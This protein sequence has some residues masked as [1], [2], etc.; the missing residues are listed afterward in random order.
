M[1]R[2]RFCHGAKLHRRLGQSAQRL[3]Q[4]ARLVALEIR[5]RLHGLDVEIRLGQFGPLGGDALAIGIGVEQDRCEAIG[6]ASP[7][8]HELDELW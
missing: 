7:G 5:R 4:N 6:A 1:G 8:T 3:V 2:R